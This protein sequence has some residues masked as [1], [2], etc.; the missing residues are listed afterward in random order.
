[1]KRSFLYML[2][3]VLSPRHSFVI[4]GYVLPSKQL[5]LSRGLLLVKNISSHKITKTNILLKRAANDKTI[6]TSDDYQPRRG[7]STRR[8]SED[9]KKEIVV[10]TLNL[11]KAMAGTGILALPMGVA[12][13][14]DFKASIIPAI[15][16]MSI[17]G[18]VS[19]YTFSLYGRL[20]H[21]SQAKTLGELWEKKMDK[22][23]GTNENVFR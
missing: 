20:I 15:A 23:S 2:V 1:M 14:S 4:M 12:K 8:K 16:L 21:A 6:S 10:G 19:A 17:L 11:I 5:H 18:A 13:S 3:V 22:N 7:G 9:T